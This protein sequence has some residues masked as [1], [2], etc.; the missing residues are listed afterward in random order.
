MSPNLILLSI[1]EGSPTFHL[2]PEAKSF[3]RKFLVRRVGAL[4]TACSSCASLPHPACFVR[5]QAGVRPPVRRHLHHI[6]AYRIPLCF[7]PASAHLGP[8][9]SWH[10]L[11]HT[12]PRSQCTS[13]A[14]HRPRRHS[15]YPCREV[16]GCGRIHGY[17]CNT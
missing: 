9:S 17:R 13:H 12:I 4:L 3:H 10:L 7:L 15:S 11:P 6:T 14:F 2:V 16:H 1:I 8:P 5:T